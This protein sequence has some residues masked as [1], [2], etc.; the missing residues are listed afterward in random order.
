MNFEDQTDWLNQ[1]SSG[2]N[3]SLIL[4]AHFS[5]LELK[6]GQVLFAPNYGYWEIISAV[7]V[8]LLPS[9]WPE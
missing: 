9:T 2:F 1:K 5:S 8:F 4:Y 7:V 3:D 6:Q